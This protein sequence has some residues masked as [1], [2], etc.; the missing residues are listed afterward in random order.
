MIE[1]SKKAVLHE[2]DVLAFTIQEGPRPL[3]A[4]MGREP[5]FIKPVFEWVNF[6]ENYVEKDY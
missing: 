5:G 4:W 6:K 2:P 3:G 1:D